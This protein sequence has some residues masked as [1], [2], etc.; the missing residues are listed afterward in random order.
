MKKTSF[1]KRMLHF[2]RSSAENR[3]HVHVF[4]G[5]LVI[6]L[7]GMLSLYFYMTFFVL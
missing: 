5:F 1:F 6:P 4:L 3:R 2:Y 7:V